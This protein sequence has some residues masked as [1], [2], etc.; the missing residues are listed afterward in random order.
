MKYFIYCRKS[1]EEESRQSQSL[2]TQRRILTD[3]ANRLE[4][5]IVDIIAESKSAKDAQNRPL[6]DDMLS[7]IRKGEADAIL[8]VHTDRLARNM[9]EAAILSDL[10]EQNILQEIRTPNQTY[11]DIQSLMYLGMEL[12]FSAQYSRDLSQKVRSGNQTKLKNG[13]YPSY[14]PIGYVNIKPGNGIEP[15]PIRAPFIRRGF[16][17]YATGEYSYQQI[18][19]K[20]YEQGLRARSGKKKSASSIARILKKSEYTGV[21]RRKGNIYPGNHQPLIP[22]EVFDA[23]QNA[24]DN[25][26]Q[27]TKTTSAKKYTYRD[28]LSC[29]VCGCKITADTAKGKDI[30]YYCTNGKNMCKQHRNYWNKTHIQKQFAS[31]FKN[32]TLDKDMAEAS[33]KSYLREA[34]NEREYAEKRMQSV[35]ESL[36]SVEKRLNKLEEMYLEERISGDR[37]D[38]RKK[39]LQNEKS[40]LQ[41]ILQNKQP[42]RNDTTLELLEELKNQAIQLE[43]IFK[44]GDDQVRRDLLRSVVSNARLRDGKIVS[45]RVKKLWKPLQG[46]NKTKNHSTWRRVWDSNPRS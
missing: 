18:A 36:E 17:L 41:T 16:E 24:I 1:S 25:R 30:Y 27:S 23:V 37:F 45:T 34:S 13:E 15:D 35:R 8:V 26:S 6:F 12:V 9:H 39:S 46:L 33:F 10:L 2:E 43:T 21:I 38:K 5:D 40:Q 32:F 7:H 4:L 3:F 19:D 22:Q 11:N 20:L 14:A 31:F 29:D 44:N 42:T 28:F